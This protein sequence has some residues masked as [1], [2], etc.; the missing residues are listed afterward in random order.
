M[1][2]CWPVSEGYES[3]SGVGLSVKGMNHGLVLACQ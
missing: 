1:V 3:W 2:W